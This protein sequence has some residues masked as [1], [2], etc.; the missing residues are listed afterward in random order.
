M[1]RLRSVCLALAVITVVALSACSS[2]DGST[3]R[4][5]DTVPDGAVAVTGT[6]Q[7]TI[8][9]LSDTIG[10]DGTEVVEERF[11]CRTTMS[12]PR[13][14]GAEEYP[15]IV[16][17]ITDPSNPVAGL[18]H[19]EGATITNDDGVWRGNGFG[20]VDLVGV[21]PLAEGVWPFNYGEVH[22][23]GEGAYDGLTLHFYISGTNYDFALAGWISDSS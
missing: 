20:V 7:C 6:S 9:P 5:G 3:L 4:T 17:R 8:Q 10:D 18:W 1:S 23:T 19:A 16:T 15:L 2:D 22:Y 13:A 14:S 11:T 12:D 21:S